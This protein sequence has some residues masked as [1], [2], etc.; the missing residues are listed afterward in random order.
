M[1]PDKKRRHIKSFRRIALLSMSAVA[2]PLFIVAILFEWTTVQSHQASVN[3]AFRSTLSAYGN[4]VENSANTVQRYVVGTAVNSI[5]FQMIVHAKNKTEAYL[6]AIQIEKQCRPLLQAHE[7]LGGFYVYTPSF[8][9]CH[10]VSMTNYPH[11]DRDRIQTAVM[12]TAATEK[13]A[14]CWMPL[15][16][17]DRTVFLYTYVKKGN[18][19]SVILDPTQQTHTG[20]EPDSKIFFT[21]EDGTPLAQETAFGDD[22]FPAPADWT[23]VF[24]SSSGEVYDLISLPLYTVP[25][26]IV[27]A[28][29]HKSFFEQLNRT[30]RFLMILTLCLLISVPVCWLLLRSLLLHPLSR[31]TATTEAIKAGHTDTRVPRDSRVYEVNAIA[32][33]VN[34]MLD[35]IQQQK[36]DAYERELSVRDL[37]LEYL[38]LQLRPHF[39][40]NCLNLIYSLAGEKKYT[41]L[42]ELAL[43]LSAYFRN[44]FKGSAKLVP[45]SSEINSIENYI[46]I[47]GTGMQFPPY[48]ELSM[49]SGTAD[50]PVPPISILT[51]VENAVKHADPVDTALLIHIKCSRLDSEEGSY[52]YITVCD[53][54]GGFPPEKLSELNNPHSKTASDGHIGISN[55]RHRLHFLYGER[56]TVSFRNRSTGACVELFLPIEHDMTGGADP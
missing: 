29:P 25:G 48:L 49:D 52:L 2:I 41:V 39:F 31:L 55:I 47:Q 46:R 3:A 24:Q 1:Q 4:M 10:V 20:L 30:Q 50:L 35:T 44:I 56:A 16:L 17:S 53:N 40:L 5:D 33:T 38:Q 12:E 42:Q 51:F 45:L 36:I 23:S 27:Y 9:Y 15:P 26:Y 43:N 37:R 22:P 19:I 13:N 34:I 54:G 8:D 6:S 21:A 28:V 32:E 11:I 14:T 7:L 18:A